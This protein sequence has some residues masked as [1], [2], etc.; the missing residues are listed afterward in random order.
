MIKDVWKRISLKVASF[1]NGLWVS[2]SAILDFFP[3][4]QTHHWYLPFLPVITSR[5]TSAGW[6]ILN[7]ENTMSGSL[8]EAVEILA[9]WHVCVG[10]E[11][12]LT[13]KF[14]MSFSFSD[15]TLLGNVPIPPFTLLLY[16]CQHFTVLGHLAWPPLCVL[17]FLPTW[18]PCQNQWI[19][20]IF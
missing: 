19:F 4:R 16:L 1:N 7:K 6:G 13:A 17:P 9:G 10:C 11:E 8:T 15:P 12:Q 2:I 18:S 20:V 3:Q 14:L 5:L